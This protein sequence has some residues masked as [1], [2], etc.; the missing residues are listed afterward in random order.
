METSSTTVI[1]GTVMPKLKV[2]NEEW[3]VVFWGQASVR[4]YGKVEIG[5]ELKWTLSTEEATI[6]RKAIKQVAPTALG[7]PQYSYEE[8]VI[9]RKGIAIVEEKFPFAE[10]PPLHVSS[11]KLTASSQC[12]EQICKDSQMVSVWV[13]SVKQSGNQYKSG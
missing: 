5:K 4:P 9:L 7:D 8:D 12:F 13:V 6:L 3:R 10:E 2:E 1:T 11:L